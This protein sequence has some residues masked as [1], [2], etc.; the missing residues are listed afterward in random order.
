MKPQ[1]INLKYY[2]ILTIDIPKSDNASTLKQVKSNIPLLRK[3]KVTENEVEE[4]EYYKQHRKYVGILPANS[5]KKLIEQ[6]EF[7]TTCNTMG[8]L[9]LEYGFV[10]A[11]SFD[12]RDGGYYGY[13][14]NAYISPIIEEKSDT[15]IYNELSDINNLYPNQLEF[16][17]EKLGNKI[18]IALNMLKEAFNNNLH[19]AK[20]FYVDFKQLYL[21]DHKDLAINKEQ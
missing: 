8:A 2:V 18:D 7:D 12:F 13:Y 15:Y 21:F 14:I 16:Y 4:P 6:C 3:F 20:S 10:P 19:F 5:I 9:T 11:V 17:R 1:R